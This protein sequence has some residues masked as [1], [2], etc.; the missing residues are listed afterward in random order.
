M[1]HPLSLWIPLLI[2]LPN[3]AFLKLQPRNMPQPAR[4]P[5]RV[6]QAA[7]MAG[8]FGTMAVPLFFKMDT[9]DLYAFLALQGMI[10][11][12]A[13]YYAGWLRYIRQNRDYNWLYAP[14]FG[15]PVPMAVSPVLYVLFAAAVLHSPLYLLFGALLGIGHLPLSYAAYRETQNRG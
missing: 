11:S 4:P 3:L 5:N 6:L 9:G 14:M 8:R 10:L 13:L 15:I 12:L 7:E 2:L 1:L